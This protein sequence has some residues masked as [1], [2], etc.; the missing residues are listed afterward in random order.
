[1]INDQKV[2]MYKSVK[3][4]RDQSPDR[5]FES[6]DTAKKTKCNSLKTSED[7]TPVRVLRSLEAS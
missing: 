7:K 6:P 2:F 1:M 3:E 5:R 4:I